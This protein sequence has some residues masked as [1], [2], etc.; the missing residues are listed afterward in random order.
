MSATRTVEEH[1]PASD[2]VDIHTKTNK[3]NPGHRA[4]YASHQMIKGQGVLM[5]GARPWCV[6][7]DL[8]E[9][10]ARARNYGLAKGYN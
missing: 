7:M 6:N 1:G 8:N 5:A 3:D 2:S 4:G 9:I 10:L